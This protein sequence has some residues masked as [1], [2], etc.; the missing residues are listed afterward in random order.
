VI[1]QITSTSGAASCPWES[2]IRLRQAAFGVLVASLL[3]GAGV[4]GALV[5]A[6]VASGMISKI[7]ARQPEVLE[8]DPA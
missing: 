3:T 2:P 7:R 8:I 4:L 6:G 1:Y 5:P